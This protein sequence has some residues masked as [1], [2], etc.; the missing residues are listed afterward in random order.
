MLFTAKS[1]LAFVAATGSIS[2]VLASP[3]PVPDPS[4]VEERQL[5]PLDPIYE[6]Q[7]A[8]GMKFQVYSDTSGSAGAI[9]R[10]D[11]VRHLLAPRARCPSG[12]QD[13]CVAANPPPQ[14]LC[15][16][17]ETQLTSLALT[18]IPGSGNSV[19][20]S[21]EVAGAPKSSC[22]AHIGSKVP[23]L[24]YG[25]LLRPTTDL[26]AECVVDNGEAGKIRNFHLERRN[27]CVTFCLDSKATGC[28]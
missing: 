26:L 15:N 19:C 10:R 17:L 16:T 23:N 5:L 4:E 28:S 24:T 20:V 7:L 12:P 2:S 27:A 8:D 9:L 6:L 3:A 13:E 11:D 1:L 22:C 14:R 21:K 25:E 18:K